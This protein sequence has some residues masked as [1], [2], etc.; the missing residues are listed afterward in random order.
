MKED[1]RVSCPRKPF[2]EDSVKAELKA[3]GVVTPAHPSRCMSVAE[4][5]EA[6]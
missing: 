3:E 5:P 4:P 6:I 1:G 2:P